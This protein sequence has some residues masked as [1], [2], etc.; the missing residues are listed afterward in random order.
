MMNDTAS[1]DTSKMTPEIKRGVISWIIKAGAGLIFFAVILFP[2]AGQWDWGWGWIFIG[3]FA[4]ASIVNVLILVPTNPAL[5]AQRSR[6]LREEGASQ[7][8]K[9]LTGMGAGLMPM[10]SWI[11]AALDA[12]FGWS[13]MPLALHLVGVLGFV[14]GWAFVLWATGSNAYFSTTVR[15]H[16]GHT[17]QTGGPYQLVRHPG[18]VGA[19]LYQLVT[20]FLLGSWWAFIPAILSAP[21]LVVR[22]A[23]EDTMLQQNLDGYQAYARQVRYRLL[24]GVW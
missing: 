22:T 21:F 14:F 19:I 16:A 24:P 12:R 3:L 5:L 7:T 2:I 23:L 9:F 11:V 17:V 1:K 6:G 4:L 18:Y 13:A 10:L 20:P 15:L 8:D